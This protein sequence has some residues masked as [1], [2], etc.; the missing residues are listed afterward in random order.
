MARVA[1]PDLGDHESHIGDDADRQVVHTVVPLAQAHEV[2][3]HGL[4]VVPALEAL[5]PEE[6][7][8]I[9]SNKTSDLNQG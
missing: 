1:T 6:R 7:R 5:S 2:S 3:G 9:I 8:E 4:D